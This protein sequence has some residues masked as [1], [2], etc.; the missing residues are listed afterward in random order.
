MELPD[1]IDTDDP[2]LIV[3]IWLNRNGQRKSPTKEST[4]FFMT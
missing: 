2:S 4:Y 3:K 1:E